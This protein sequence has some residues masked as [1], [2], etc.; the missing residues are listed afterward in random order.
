[1]SKWIRVQDRLP[2]SEGEYLVFRPKDVIDNVRTAFF[3]RGEFSCLVDPTH[4][5][6]L[7]PPPQEP[8]P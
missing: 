2:D 8:Q 3:R 6:P 1:M 5:M 4:W 7:P